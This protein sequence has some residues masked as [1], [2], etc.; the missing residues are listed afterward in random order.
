MQ[1]ERHNA[2][3]LRLVSVLTLDDV[4]DEDAG[5]YHCTVHTAYGVAY[6][7]SA[8]LIV[9][10]QCSVH[11]LSRRSTQHELLAVLPHFTKR[12]I[13]ST[14]RIGGTARLQCAA[15]GRPQPQI[16][17]SMTG[18]D[19]FAAARE[20]R[21]H[22]LSADAAFFI[23]DVRMADDGRRS[24]LCSLLLYPLKV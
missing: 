5:T 2:S 12:P 7:H 23:T 14:V 4:A 22:V 9:N 3:A 24:S 18:G 20:R 16:R 1:I 17:W 19:D 10:G 21:V 11:H 13:D 15:E 8:D 6:S